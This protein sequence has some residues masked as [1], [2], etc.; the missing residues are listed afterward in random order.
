[1]TEKDLES[2]LSWRNSEKVRAVMFTD[3][4]ITPE[5]HRRWFETLQQKPSDR[6][7]VF[8][9]RG[10]PAGLAYFTGIDPVKARCAW[11]FY[12]GTEKLPNGAG[13]VMALLA[14]DDAFDHLPIREVIGE[15][16]KF[17][18]K[19]VHYQERLGFRLSNTPQYREKAG[20]QEE[21]LSF[22]LD[23]PTWQ[24]KRGDIRQRM[25][26]GN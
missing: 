9:Y 8:E 2:V 12:L 13:T 10:K 21:V 18:Q 26:G 15:S 4:L 11:G 3:H 24:S 17:N 16:F 25:L 1:M 23:K 22:V 14:L 7:L 19:A 6:Y 20:R 5:E